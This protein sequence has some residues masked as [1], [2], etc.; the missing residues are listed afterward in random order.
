VT[1]RSARLLAGSGLVAMLGGLSYLGFVQATRGRTFDPG[2]MLAGRPV[3]W[4]A[5]QAVAV[6]AVLAAVALG[7]H[8]WRDRR[9]GLLLL[10]LTAG[11]VF[12]PWAA[13]WGLLLP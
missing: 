9:D 13:Y 6:V 1:P 10:P 4:L 11:V 8:H 3:P 7:V 2:P 5:L 12:V